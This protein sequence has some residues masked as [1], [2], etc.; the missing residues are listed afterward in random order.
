MRKADFILEREQGLPS[1][2]IE[3]ESPVHSVFT[4][5]GDLTAQSNHARQQVSE[6]VKYV[7]NEPQTNAKDEYSFLTGPKERMVV[8]GRGIENKD[9]LI[10]TKYDGVTFWTYSIMLEEAK[11]RM[12]KRLGSIYIK[13]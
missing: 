10:D 12:N 6:W 5:K 3:L 7:E 9:R 13:G 2:F 1:I 4:K 8:I 11:S